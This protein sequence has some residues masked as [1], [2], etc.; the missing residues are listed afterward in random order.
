[1]KLS[2]SLIKKIFITL[3]GLLFIA[4]L[5]VFLLVRSIYP[6]L[7]DTRT[8]QDVQLQVPLRVYSADNKL[9]GEYG[10]IK[11]IPLHYD[12]FPE[13]MINAFV[14]A[15]DDRFF[16]HPGV[17]YQGILRAAISLIES[18]KKK[19]GG[20]TITMQVAKNYLL[21][22]DK[23]FKRKF[24]EI[25]LSLK[26]E[27]ELSK[28]E[29]L[30]LY[31]NKIFFG[32]RAYSAAAAA[33]VYYGVEV[34]DLTLPQMAMIAGLPQAPSAANPVTNKKK[35]TKRR[36]Y[37]LR[38]MFELG[39]IDEAQYEEAKASEDDATLHSQAL[40]I[41]APYVAE[42]VRSE[43]I[44]RYGENAYDTGLSVYTTID[45]H[46]QVAA[47][48]ALRQALQDYDMRHGYRGHIKTIEDTGDEVLAGEESMQGVLSELSGPP[49]LSPAI[50][51]EVDKKSAYVYTKEG[52]YLLLP[53]EGIAWARKYISDTA[54][55]GKLKSAG[56]VLKPGDVIYVRISE[57]G[58]W[59]LAQIPLVSGA[60][61]ALD[62]NDGKVKALVGGYDFYASKF[63]RVTQGERQPGSN[64]KPFL[65]ASAL[66]NGF[67][68][69]SVINDAPVVVDDWRPKN[70]SGKFYGP[71]RMREALVRSINLVS[72]R[73]LQSMGIDTG[74]RYIR[75][76][77]FKEER[78]PRNFS[79]ALGSVTLPPIELISAYAV[80][81]NG[82]YRVEPYYIKRIENLEGDI[83]MHSDPVIV[84]KDC[85]DTGPEIIEYRPQEESQTVGPFPPARKA[86]R[87]FDQRAIYLV[88]DVM[89]DVVQ[90]GTARRA[91][92]LGRSDLAGKTGT[93]NDQVDAWFSGFNSQLVATAWVGFDNPKPMGRGETG[94]RAALPMWIYFMREA[95]KDIPEQKQATPNDIVTI[96]IDATTGEYAGR[97]S[98]DTVF[99]IF[100]SENAPQPP[101]IDNTLISPDATNALEATEEL[102]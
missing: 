3:F 79:L 99:E 90:R 76:F 52:R 11:R 37:V 15:E 97:D 74:I 31:L 48:H 55:G 10:E 62:P 19:Q 94:S 6:E 44:E 39:H 77:G 14:A 23:T 82:G 96:R 56:Q 41:E 5:G 84:C 93:T 51:I 29:I 30:E 59:R 45:S 49:D 65:Y 43:V 53:W 72:V 54:I 35:A 34:Q 4:V 69:A 66:E 26:M 38:R 78:L 102:F 32:Q 36:N 24:K 73:L 47:N 42:M 2:K 60:L 7:P 25:L 81:A 40:E 64:F 63:N 9:I 28:E 89:R 21:T 20:S 71:T 95:L 61:V 80:L 27:T 98:E 83:I 13:Q 70:Y 87:V 16:E 86:A 17:D 33:Q 85:N 12:D 18:G 58:H 67:T 92:V 50:V 57:E 75:H 1:M 101:K 100:R 8:L 68:L 88:T 46:Q 91:K 22:R